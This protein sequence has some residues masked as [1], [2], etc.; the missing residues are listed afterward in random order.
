MT[1]SIPSDADL[2]SIRTLRTAP[3]SVACKPHH[4]NADAAVET[5]SGGAAWIAMAHHPTV[6]RCGKRS[7][8]QHGDRH[9]ATG[10][11]ADEHLCGACYRTFTPKDQERAFEH[12]QPE[13]TG[14]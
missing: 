2:R 7:F 11:L 1:E 3:I 5:Q 9:E 12:E 10:R 13:L 4:L 8:S 6:A 14:E